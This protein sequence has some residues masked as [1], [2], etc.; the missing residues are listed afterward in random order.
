MIVTCNGCNNSFD[1]DDI[2]LMPSGR[3]LKCS[4]CKNVFFQPPPVAEETKAPVS[5]T[6]IPKYKINAVIRRQ[7]PILNQ[8]IAQYLW[9]VYYKKHSKSVHTK[10]DLNK[11]IEVFIEELLE[12]LMNFDK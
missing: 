11:L 9:G 8:Y 3:K 12:H 5:K 1:V 7:F 6:E 2:M 10:E 4:A